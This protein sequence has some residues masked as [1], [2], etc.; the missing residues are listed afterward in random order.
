LRSDQ[1]NNPRKYERVPTCGAAR[2]FVRR[3]FPA[4][5]CE[6]TSGMNQPRGG[7]RTKTFEM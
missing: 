7:A 3:Q 4:E 5:A 6:N 1:T 2:L